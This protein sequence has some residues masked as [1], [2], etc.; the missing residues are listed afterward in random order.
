MIRAEA[1]RSD[2]R[3]AQGTSLD[4][5]TFAIVRADTARLIPGPPSSKGMIGSGRPKGVLA[6]RREQHEASPGGGIAKN[7]PSASRTL[8]T[9]SKRSALVGERRP[10]ALI[11]ADSYR[12]QIQLIAST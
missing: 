10:P 12:E 6:R 11:Q 5:G 4:L 9:S 3:A 7:K 2:L 8:G 1:A